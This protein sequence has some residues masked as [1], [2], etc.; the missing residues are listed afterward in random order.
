ML[1]RASITAT[2]FTA[3]LAFAPGEA[4]AG[5]GGDWS[6]ID[7]YEVDD[8]VPLVHG[9][10]T[11]HLMSAALVYMPSSVVEFEENPT[12]PPLAGTGYFTIS[13]SI[14]PLPTLFGAVGGLE[15]D[16]SL[17]AP[18]TRSYAGGLG[19][20][21]GLVVQPIS[22]KHLRASVAVGGGFNAHGYG[23]VKPR[24]AFTIVPDWVEAEA[25]YRW[26]PATAS[27]VFGGKSDGL[28]DEGF[29][30]HKL[31]GSLFVRVG[32]QGK[33]GFGAPAIHAFFEYT[34]VSGDED[35]LARV[36]IRPGD[37][38]GFGLGF[39]Y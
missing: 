2:L 25:W 6:P 26:I 21:F 10:G 1:L 17:G 23:Y 4:Q 27:N 15:A 36:R 14:L 32:E 33:E 9:V 7:E 34:R 30:E 29:G 5:P 39:A 20:N 11:S 8:L 31:R 19:G 3:A 16:L 37:Y 18:L 22:W 24:I 13:M 12:D 28:E 38:M 35:E